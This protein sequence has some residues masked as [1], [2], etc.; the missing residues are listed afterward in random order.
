MALYTIVTD[1]IDSYHGDLNCSRDNSG[2]LGVALPATIQVV[3][4]QYHIYTLGAKFD[5]HVILT[6]VDLF[7]SYINIFKATKP[8]LFH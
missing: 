2:S 6:S 8:F 5:Y 7:L 4:E 1:I 3:K